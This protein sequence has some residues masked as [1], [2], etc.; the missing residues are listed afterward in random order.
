MVCDGHRGGAD[1]ARASQ[2]LTSH[3]AVNVP[4]ALQTQVIPKVEVSADGERQDTGVLDF[5]N[6]LRGHHGKT[7]S[8]IDDYMSKHDN[9][10][11]AGEKS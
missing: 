11:R 3:V 10:R 8:L 7:S 2:V 9:L 6:V 1:A 5:D 4:R